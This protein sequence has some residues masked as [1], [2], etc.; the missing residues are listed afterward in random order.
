[1]MNSQFSAKKPGWLESNTKQSDIILSTRVRFARNIDSIPFPNWASETGLRRVIEVIRETRKDS[2][3]IKKFRFINFHKLSEINRKFLVERHQISPA[4][5]SL[6]YKRAM[7]LENSE[8]ASVMINEEDHLRLQVIKPG[9]SVMNTW[10]RANKLDNE[11]SKFIKFSKSEKYGY[12]TACPTNVGTAIRVSFLCHLPG[13][14]L[15]QQMEEFLK[16]LIPAGIAV[17]GIYGEGSDIVGNIF[18]IS[19]QTTLGYNQEDIL[20]RLRI[21]AKKILS[22][23]TKARTKLYKDLGRQLEDKVYRAIG[24][25]TSAR[26]MSTLEL[27]SLLSALRLGS[28]LG[29]IKPVKPSTINQLIVQCQPMH[30]TKIS[31]LKPDQ[32]EIDTFRAEYVRKKLKLKSVL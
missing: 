6:S 9:L 27:M 1:M 16:Y 7:L 30:I 24:I 13:L 23:E 15:T 14:A 5:L 25:I 11:F 21:V 32:E 22:M 10:R 20:K 2:S 19:N 17:R 4:F 31:K 18:Q 8:E 3:L 29:I 26:L 12:L 28:W